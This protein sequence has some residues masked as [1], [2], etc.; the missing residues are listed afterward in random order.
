MVKKEKKEEKEEKIEQEKGKNP[1]KEKKTKQEKEKY[2]DKEKKTKQE[3]EKYPDK[4]KKR[5]GKKEKDIKS[6][7]RKF[8]IVAILLLALIVVTAFSLYF[9]SPL[10]TYTRPVF[11]NV[12]YPVAVVGRSRSVI[13]SAS[14]IQSTDAVQMFYESQDL[15][16]KGFRVDFTT[17]EGKMRLKIKEKD[18]FNKLVE[19]KI[20][21]E[22]ARDKG[23]AITR[24]EAQKKLDEKIAEYGTKRSLE[25]SLKSLYGWN[26]S[27][28]RDNVVIYQI[29]LKRL[30]GAYIFE[31]TEQEGYK[32][33]VEASEELNDAGSNFVDVVKT[34]S[35]GE[36]AQSDGEL[37][38]FRY[39]QLI[40]EVADV[41][42]AMNTGEISDVIVS[43][44]GFHIVQ[45]QETRERKIITDGESVESS[46]KDAAKTIKEVKIRQIYVH[47]TT[48]LDWILEQ[49][50][51]MP[52]I[53]L[54]KDYVWNPQQGEIEFR[55][56]KMKKI[57]RKI[58]MNSE[59][60]PSLGNF[61]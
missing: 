40:P 29:Y 55:D 60:D 27:D 34:Y 19:N 57:E 2:P 51:Q 6:L 49:K 32:K 5:S 26:I 15:T 44:I 33:C 4:G 35:E 3:K 50:K 36:S 41:V 37:G 11:K 59:G 24:K 39:H 10:E 54:M 45:V 42:F 61:Q 16:S 20:V 56:Q 8:L 52:V 53:V 22:L 30:F 17:K 18:V 25:L 48:F 7:F 12:P 31:I 23:I 43:P 46:G 21:E 58:R 1:D 13:T 28:F 14:L 38:W 47:G 9:Y